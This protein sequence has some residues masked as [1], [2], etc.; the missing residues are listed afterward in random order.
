MS[1]N[2]PIQE[3]LEAYTLGALDADEQTQVQRHLATCNDC[4]RLVKEYTELANQLPQALAAASPLPLPPA[5]K[6]RVMRS[7]PGEPSPPR[8]RPMKPIP[9]DSRAEH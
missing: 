8:S 9:S 1:C 5:I 7:V 2:D 3:L 6:T 4:Q